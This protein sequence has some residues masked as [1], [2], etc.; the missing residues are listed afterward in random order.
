MINFVVAT[1]I[2]SLPIIEFYSLKQIKSDSIFQV[3][4][5]IKTNIYLIISGI[6]KI[7]SA[8]ATT[9]LFAIHTKIKNQIWINI[10]ICGHID[11]PVGNGYLVNKITDKSTKQNF[12]PN[13][14]FSHNFFTCGCITCDKPNFKYCQSL[15]DMESSGFFSTALKFSTSELVHLFKVISDN[16]ANR[17][18]QRDKS[19]VL[20]LIRNNLNLIDK[21]VKKLKMIN[22]KNYKKNQ[23]QINEIQKQFFYF[24]KYFNFQEEEKNK[25]KDMLEDWNYIRNFESPI[26]Y[27]KKITK[28]NEI[29]LELRKALNN[30]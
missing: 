27:L 9:Y 17:I 16:Q 24:C 11:H 28:K 14:A 10:G 2:E 13:L 22:K 30:D 19:Y 23:N 8:S 4:R 26:K 20:G 18:I 3:F 29:F 21:L 15:Y 7:K 1:H 12:Y 5:N 25:L 6:G